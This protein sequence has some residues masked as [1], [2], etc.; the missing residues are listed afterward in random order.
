MNKKR[1]VA[2]V[3]YS[4]RELGKLHKVFFAKRLNNESGDEN[5]F[6]RN[7]MAAIKAM[8]DVIELNNR[9]ISQ[10]AGILEIL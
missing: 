2:K 10:D 3:G 6:H 9:K 5:A 1:I 4:R 7:L 8:L